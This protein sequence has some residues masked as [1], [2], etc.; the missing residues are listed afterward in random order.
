[1]KPLCKWITFNEET[2]LLTDWA[3]ELN[4]TPSSLLNRLE[5]WS[6]EAALTTAKG[7]KQN[8]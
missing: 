7:A 3:R 8:D 1:M 2:K 4:I 5:K 6:L